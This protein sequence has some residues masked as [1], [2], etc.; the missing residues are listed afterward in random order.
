MAQAA[1]V[2]D[3]EMESLQDITSFPRLYIGDI[4]RVGMSSMRVCQSSASR[5]SQASSIAINHLIASV[6]SMSHEERAVIHNLE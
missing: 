2:N 1:Q 4:L 3:V 6:T 5:C